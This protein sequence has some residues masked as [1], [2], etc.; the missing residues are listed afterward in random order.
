[1]YII[2]FCEDNQ[3]CYYRCICRYTFDFVFKHSGEINQ[4][5]KIIFIPSMGGWNTRIL[6]EGIITNQP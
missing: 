5:Y 6:S 2:D 3:E 4:M 1:M